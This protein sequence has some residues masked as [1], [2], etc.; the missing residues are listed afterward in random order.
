MSAGNY[1]ALPN[2]HPRSSP[3]IPMICKSSMDHKPL[4]PRVWFHGNPFPQRGCG[5]EMCTASSPVGWAALHGPKSFRFS[6]QEST[7]AGF[8]S[9]AD[10]SRLHSVGHRTE[11][12]GST[13]QEHGHSGASEPHRPTRAASQIR[14]SLPT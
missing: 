7:Q 2:P 9:S 14:L 4:E 10:T 13:D 3:T 5:A 12:S 6:L 8:P 1:D 11:P